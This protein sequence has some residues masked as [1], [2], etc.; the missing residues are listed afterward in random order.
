M[1][2][3]LPDN[4]APLSREQLDELACDW[5]DYRKD[6]GADPKRNAEDHGLYKLAWQ[7]GHAAALREAHRETNR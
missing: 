1:T 2:D 7:A 6:Y 5:S 4:T 3:A